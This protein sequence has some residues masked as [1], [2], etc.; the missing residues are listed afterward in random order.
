MSVPRTPGVITQQNVVLQEVDDFIAE[1]SIDPAIKLLLRMGRRN[2]VTT[3]QVKDVQE[4]VVR[5]VDVL[6]KNPSLIYLF[7][8]ETKKTLATGGL[9]LGGAYFIYHILEAMFGLESFIT[10]WIP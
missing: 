3:E 1:N 6:E 9:V 10:S 4:V 7:R 8:T 5:K 2:F